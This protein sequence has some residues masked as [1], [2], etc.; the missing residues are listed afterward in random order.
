M[1]I[2]REAL[3]ILDRMAREGQESLNRR[4][5]AE[6]GRMLPNA[7]P[8]PRRWPLRDQNLRAVREL[9]PADR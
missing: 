9:E 7:K 4:R 1:K 2:P 5:E 6:M 8:E 3:R